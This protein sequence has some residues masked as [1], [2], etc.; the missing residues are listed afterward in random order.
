MEG[1]DYIW[2]S[3]PIFNKI[4]KNDLF[5]MGIKIK[6]RKKKKKVEKRNQTIKNLIKIFDKP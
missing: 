2:C 5:R 6:R 4:R 1:F 3:S